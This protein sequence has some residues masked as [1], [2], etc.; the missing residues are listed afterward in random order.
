MSDYEKRA[1]ILADAALRIAELKAEQGTLTADDLAAVYSF[2]M[3]RER[4]KA[5]RKRME[6]SKRLLEECRQ[7]RISMLSHKEPGPTRH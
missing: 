1:A 7:L 4:P 6:E 5:I 2:V 3:Q